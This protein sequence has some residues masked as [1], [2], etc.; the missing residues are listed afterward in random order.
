MHSALS[1]PQKPKANLLDLVHPSFHEAA[2]D[3]EGHAP[4][5]YASPPVG[6]PSSIP[7]PGPFVSIA[8]LLDFIYA[9]DISTVEALLNTAA[10]WPKWHDATSAQAIRA[11]RDSTVRRNMADWL[12]D[13]T[14]ASLLAPSDVEGRQWS[15]CESL[16]I[17][18]LL[19]AP[20]FVNAYYWLNELTGC[21]FCN[22]S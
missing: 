14:C 19:L 10:T 1:I 13:D 8:D 20:D 18:S 15:D 12:V 3:V 4:Y 7:L 2:P 11:L 21:G 6:A 22:Y 16:L 9:H 5:G 17:K